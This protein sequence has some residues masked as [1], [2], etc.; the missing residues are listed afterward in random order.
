MRIRSILGLLFSVSFTTFISAAPLFQAGNIV[1]GKKWAI[2]AQSGMASYFADGKAGQVEFSCDLQGKNEIDEPKALL[3]TGKNFTNEHNL[4][5][6][7]LSKGLN[8]PFI[9]TLTDTNADVGN[10]KIFYL[11][12]EHVTVQC[13]GKKI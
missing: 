9:W 12:G 4:F 6:T 1:E 10:I 2:D 13:F 5:Q 3:R 8:G 11:S 7:I